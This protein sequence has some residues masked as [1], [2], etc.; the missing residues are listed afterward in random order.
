MNL[1]LRFKIVLDLIV[2]ILFFIDLKPR[3]LPVYES[4]SFL[5]FF[6]K[7]FLKN[8]EISSSNGTQ[9]LFFNKLKIAKFDIFSCLFSRLRTIFFIFYQNIFNVKSYLKINYRIM[10]SQVISKLL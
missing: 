10:S 1:G 8:N 9:T 4:R 7:Q 3:R 6:G 2:S 5:N